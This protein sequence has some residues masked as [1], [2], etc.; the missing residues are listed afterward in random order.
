MTNF[1][2]ITYESAGVSVK[3]QNEVNAA[4]VQRLRKMGMKAEGLFGGA[5]DVSV[6]K[7]KNALLDIAGATFSSSISQDMEYYGRLMAKFAFENA[8]GKDIGTL[9]YFASARM[10]DFIADFVEGVAVESLD[11]G[12]HVLGG[13]SAQMQDTYKE[14]VFDAFVHVLSIRDDKGYDISSIINNMDKPLLVASTDGTGTKTKIVRNP[15]DIIYH[16]FNDIGAQGAKPVAFALYISG[17]VDES[18]L[19][20]ID[21]KAD[22]I[23]KTLGV[24]KLRSIIA[25]KDGAYLA[26]E[27]DIAGTVIGI[28]DKKDFIT[29]AG[30]KEGDIVIGIN[31]D[32]LMTNG[33]TLARKLCNTFVEEGIVKGFDEPVLELNGKSLRHE[34]SKPH[35]PMTDIL[36]GY[37]N[38]AGVLSEFEGDIKG[39]AHITGGGQPDNIIRMIPNE[40]KVVVRRDVLP[41]P[42]LMQLFRMHGTTNDVLYET[43]NMGIGFTLTVSEEAAE[44]VVRYINEHFRYRVEGVDRQAARIGTIMSRQNNQSRFEL[45]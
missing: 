28:I 26:G 8:R 38:I 5:V 42:P 40:Y 34:L 9:D 25:K 6:F 44:P 39:T 33:Y 13:E 32:G 4:V 41:V 19:K 30:V 10:G 16:G 24:G 43:F 1:S 7:G 45:V 12:C 20:S 2:N 18:E 15:E 21:K 27:V 22:Y 35:R 11:R 29:G 23:S 37:D 3:A 31:V 14:G 36:F 17:A